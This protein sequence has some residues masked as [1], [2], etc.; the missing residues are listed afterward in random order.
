MS[1]V[2]SY[3]WNTSELAVGYD[4]A[5]AVIHPHYLANQDVILDLLPANL[6]PRALVV[7]LGGGSGRLMERI[8]DRWPQVQGVV[9][10]Q[11]EPFLPLAECRLALFG[12]RAGC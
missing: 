6:G 10:D 5:A 12:Q 4:T 11:S 9:V 3:R 1:P 7:D 8:L 2:A